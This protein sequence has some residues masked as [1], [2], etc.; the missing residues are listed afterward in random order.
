MLFVKGAAVGAAQLIPGVSG[1]T[2]A[3]VL[4]IYQDLI[5]SI[6]A[7][8]GRPFLRAL[9]SGRLRTAFQAVNGTFLVTLTLGI[10]AAVPLFSGLLGWLLGR[11]PSLVF[12]FFFGLVGA[13][14]V[15]VGRR[16]KPWSPGTVAMAVVGT[17]AGFLV[18]GL[19]PAAAPGGALSLALSGALAASALVLPGISGAFILILLGQYNTALEAVSSANLRIL[20]PLALGA[21]VGLLSVARVLSWLLDRA[22]GPTLALLT[23]FM[24]GSLRKLWPWQLA[25]DSGGVNTLPPSLAA[26]LVA[27]AVAVIGSLAIIAIDRGGRER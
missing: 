10:S 5:A 15:A 17:I 21:V 1:G 6:G 9:V 25:G 22:Y 7:I 2:M 20:V 8:T 4:G 18:V 3:L 11:Y 23:G 16:V 12:A 14:T 13:S 19:A 26:A 27:S 24:V